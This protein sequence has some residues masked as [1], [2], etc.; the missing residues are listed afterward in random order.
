VLVGGAAGYR[1]GRRGV[2]ALIAAYAACALAAGHAGAATRPCAGSA[3]RGS[4]AVVPGSAGAGNIVYRLHIRNRS[5]A[6]C[7]V[8]A[9]PRMVLLDARG[10]ALPTHVL[11]VGPGKSTRLVILRPGG[12]A[13]VDARFSPDVPGP[14]EG[15]TGRCEPVAHRLRIL[16]PG[17]GAAVVAI[18]PPTSVCEH[19]SL[20][21]RVLSA[22]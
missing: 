11:A 3:L 17:G 7:A 21:L 12:G 5:S 22:G 4:F 10:R 2:Y 1:R 14:G 20:Q 18:A 16:A 8:P 6:A 13:H 15:T 19:G 9:R